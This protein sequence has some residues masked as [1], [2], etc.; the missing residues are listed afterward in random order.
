MIRSNAF[1]KILENRSWLIE[2]MRVVRVALAPA[3]SHLFRPHFG[4]PSPR[5]LRSD[6]HW[7][8]NRG[9]LIGRKYHISVGVRGLIAESAYATL[10]DGL[11]LEPHVA[12]NLRRRT[13]RTTCEY[14]RVIRHRRREL[15][16]YMCPGGITA[17]LRGLRRVG[18]DRPPTLGETREEAVSH[19]P[20]ADPDPPIF[21]YDTTPPGNR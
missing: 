13:H 9:V 8:A 10:I 16:Q 19:P 20:A 17:K 2:S 15:E 14:T 21:I 11:R 5:E 3:R 4:S 6:A 1:A 18:R 7:R 12:T